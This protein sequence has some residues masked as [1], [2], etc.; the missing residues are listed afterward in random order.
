MVRVW[1]EDNFGLAFGV[2]NG[3]LSGDASV[4][5]VAR[6]ASSS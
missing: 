3:G 6:F 5:R 1:K 4:Y 2:G